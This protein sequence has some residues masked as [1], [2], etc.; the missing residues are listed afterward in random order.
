MIEK[1]LKKLHRQELLKLLLD[2]S[3]EASQMQKD[4]EEAQRQIEIYNNSNERLA[5]K[6]EEKEALISKLQ[7]RR[8]KKERRIKDLKTEMSIWRY[9]R[10]SELKESEDLAEAALRLNGLFKV[11]QQA[12]DQYLYNIRQRSVGFE[13]DVYEMPDVV[14]GSEN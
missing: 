14:G 3:R 7:G 4:Y 2:Q 11:A 6:L 10:D 1:E 9:N 5:F 8:S 13:R 12:A